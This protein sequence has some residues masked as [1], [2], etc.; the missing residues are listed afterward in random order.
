MILLY[1]QS[2][3]LC[4]NLVNFLSDLWIATRGEEDETF[5]YADI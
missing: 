5:D 2:N 4:L 3:S 1:F